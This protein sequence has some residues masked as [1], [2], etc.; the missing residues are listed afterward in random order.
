MRPV[1]DVLG[2]PAFDAVDGSSTGTRVPSMWVL[3]GHRMIRRSQVMQTITTVGL[4]IAKSVFQV[5]CVDA[6]G[7]VVLRRQLKRRYVLAFFQKLP[8]CLVGIE[9]CALG[10]E[11]WCNVEVEDLRSDGD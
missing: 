4:D 6:D 3:L 10:R 8:P 7:K 2:T 11:A 1:A 9:A 5:H